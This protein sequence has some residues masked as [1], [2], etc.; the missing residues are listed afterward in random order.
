MLSSYSDGAVGEL[1]DRDVKRLVKFSTIS[2]TDLTRYARA[3]ATSE[4]MGIAHFLVPWFN[5]R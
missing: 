3:I 4:G 5:L 2:F 1:V